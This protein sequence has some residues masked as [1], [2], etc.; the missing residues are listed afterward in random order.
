MLD[1][2][3]R[4]ALIIVM[5]GVELERP[6]IHSDVIGSAVAQSV[7]LE[8][9]GEEVLGSI[10]AVAALCLLVGVSIM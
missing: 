7:E 5:A 2:S 6:A 10:P 9:R 4:F 3:G 8:T 1:Q